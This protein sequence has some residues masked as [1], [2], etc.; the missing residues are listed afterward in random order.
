MYKCPN[1]G[2]SL[3]AGAKFCHNCG[4]YCYDLTYNLVAEQKNTTNIKNQNNYN[5]ENA[6]LVGKPYKYKFFNYKANEHRKK[7]RRRLILFVIFIS[8]ILSM[9]VIIS[10]IVSYYNKQ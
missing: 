6:T 7:M 2:T 4:N 5:E 8:I 1:C 3:V 10:L 9:Y